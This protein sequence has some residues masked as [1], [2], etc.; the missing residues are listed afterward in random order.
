[1]RERV[2]ERLSR[3]QEAAAAGNYPKAFDALKSVEKMRN[4][5]PYEKAQLYTSYGY[6]YFTQE[7]YTQ[8]ID[9][10]EKVLLQENL[11]AALRATTVYTLA[12]LQFQGEDYA[13]AI[14]YLDAW[15][16]TAQNPGPGPF[17]LQGQAYYQMGRYREAVVPVEKAIAIAREREITIQENWYLLLR[18]FYFELEEY[19]KLV[20]VLDDLITRYPRKEYWIHLAAAYGELG[21]ERR[22][23]A[24]YE[25]AHAGGHLDR[26]ADLFALGQ[27]LLQ[28]NVPYR[29]GV[30]LA[31]GLESGVIETTAESYRLLSQAWMMAR[32][33]TRAIEALTKAASLS[34]DGELDARLAQ[35]YANTGDWTKTIETCRSALQK[36]VEDAHE[37]QIM[38]GMAFFELDRYEDAKDAF[39]SAEKSVDGRATASQWIMFIEREEERLR[40]LRRVLE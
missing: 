30:V 32:E 11:P 2:Y 26:G 13:K 25:V 36:G 23:L 27:L 40:E 19:P 14:D 7:K 37:I 16:A 24:A 31:D 5:E 20:Q 18:V 1:M 21:D 34:G 6:I 3:A 17:V 33:D 10:Y 35:A 8:S 28:A 12:Q 29:A 9:A 38:M 4:L 39:R 15:L 22:Q